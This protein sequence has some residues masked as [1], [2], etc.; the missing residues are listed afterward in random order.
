MILSIIACF[1]LGL[2]S[3]PSSG[4]LHELLLYSN[5]ILL[6]AEGVERGTEQ[7]R[8]PNRDSVE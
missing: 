6:S 3:F 5:I 2:L 8:D 7:N 1:W 4:L